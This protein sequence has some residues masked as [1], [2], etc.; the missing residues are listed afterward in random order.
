MIFLHMK[1]YESKLFHKAK[2]NIAAAEL[3]QGD[4]VIIGVSGGADSMCLLYLARELK[5]NALVVHVNYKKRG[6]ESDKD[7]ELVEQLSF[8]WGFDCISI[9]PDEQDG[10]VHNFQDWARQKRYEAFRDLKQEYNAK[11]IL[12]GHHLDDQME[13]ILQKIFRGAA[14]TAW[15]GMKIWD[16]EILRPLLDFTK[17]EILEYC[18]EVNIP[19]RTDLSNLESDYARNFLRN[20]FIP[21]MDR[22][23]PGWKNNLLELK[24]YS[25]SA[26]QAFQKLSEE[27]VNDDKIMLE[28]LLKH[29]SELQTALLNTIFENKGIYTTKGELLAAKELIKSQP[30]RHIT[31]NDQFQVIRERAYLLIQK[32]TH[33]SSTKIERLLQKDELKNGVVTGNVKISLQNTPPQPPA[34]RLDANAL[35]WPLKL[36]NWQKGDKIMPFGMQGNQKISDHLTNLKITTINRENTLVLS[37]SGGTIYAIILPEPKGE[38]Q[39][40]TISE[41]ARCTEQTTE[42]LTINIEHK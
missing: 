28:E 5:L 9:V 1:K 29:P 14:I 10:T 24:E 40:G 2:E 21:E 3:K 42:Y 25:K 13:T 36:R 33:R 23:F 8:I 26:A 31:M 34:L 4:S 19:Y 27:I 7:Q 39:I 6:E 22:F 20:E 15:Q 41:L 32:T 11:A 12:I 37:S 17:Q 16:G 30:G 18:D 38:K 35:K